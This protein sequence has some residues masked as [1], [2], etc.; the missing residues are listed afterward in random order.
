MGR[1]RRFRDVGLV[2]NPTRRA[3]VSLG[4]ALIAV[5]RRHRLGVVADD[6]ASTVL[7][8]IETVPKRELFGRCDLI[9][10]LGGDGTLLSLVPYAG[11]REVPVLGINVGRLG[12]LTATAADEAR[13]ALQAVLQGEYEC[14][15]RLMLHAEVR[16]G[17]RRA[18]AHQ[19]LNDVVINKSVL[20]RIVELETQVDGHYLCTYKGDGL[21]IAT[22]TGSTAYSLSAGGPIVE[23]SV[24]VIVLA[25]ICPHTLTNRPM[26]LDDRSRVEVTLRT[27]ED[28]AVTLDGREGM[29][30]LPG[31]VVRV[32]RSPYRLPLVRVAGRTYYEVLRNKL[33]WGER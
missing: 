21:I 11:A 19:I 1:R 10:V 33:R 29:S 9:V 30:L 3:A 24:G 32:R 5:L 17:G 8:G 13:R 2:I 25:P 23:P 7:A 28:V 6:V 27:D 12:F 26:V 15:A 31:D 16:R 4:R 14:E 20:A 18:G 22:P